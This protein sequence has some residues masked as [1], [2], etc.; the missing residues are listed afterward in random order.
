MDPTPAEV[1]ILGVAI[2]IILFPKLFG[3]G[4]GNELETIGIKAEDFRF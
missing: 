3:L 2:L 4:N 1:L